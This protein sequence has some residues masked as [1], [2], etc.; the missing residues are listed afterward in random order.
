MK[1]NQISKFQPNR[2]TGIQEKV[3]VLQNKLLGA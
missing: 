1:E 3:H 2:R